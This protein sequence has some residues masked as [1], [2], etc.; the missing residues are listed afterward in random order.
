METF[1]YDDYTRNFL[2]RRRGQAGSRAPDHRRRAGDGLPHIPVDFGQHRS[3]RR[4]TGRAGAAEAYTVCG[5][6]VLEAMVWMVAMRVIAAKARSEIVKGTY[7]P[8][9][10]RQQAGAAGG[11]NDRDAWYLLPVYQLKTIVSAAMFEGLGFFA[12]IAY[13]VE[14]NPISLGIAMFMI[15]CVAAH[16]PTQG[17]IVGWVQGQLETVEVQKM[18]R[19]Q[20]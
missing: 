2:A 19:E 20:G 9:D 12:T 18:M 13:L 5:F 14:R 7:E 4:A 15:L 3:A 11:A 16:F 6:A 17:R 10:P 8:F 1:N